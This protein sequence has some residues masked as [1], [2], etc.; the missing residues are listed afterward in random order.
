MQQ[1]IDIS[2]ALTTVAAFWHTA[3]FALGLL[4]VSFS[5]MSLM[6]M[7]PYNGKWSRLIRQ[8]DLHLWIS[9]IALISLGVWQKGFDVYFSNPKLWSKITIVFIWMLSTQL[10]RRVGLQALKRGN[11][12]PMLHLSA[13]NISCW[14]YGAFLG[15]ANSLGY[16][17]LSYAMFLSGFALLNLV[18][19]LIIVNAIRSVPVRSI[20]N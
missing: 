16:G 19:L 5:L 9:G 3:G 12:V 7:L 13:I 14:I 11:R 8:A 1:V 10:M 20:S 2:G 17:G 15:C 4:Y 6:Q 18:V